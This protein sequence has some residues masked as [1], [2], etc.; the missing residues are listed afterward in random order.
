MLSEV[1]G[2]MPGA[3]ADSLLFSIAEQL[4]LPLLQIARQAELGVSVGRL[5]TAELLQM[6]QG[7]EIALKLVDSYLLGLQLC[8]EQ[9]SLVLEPVSLS[10]T[11][12]DIAHQLDGFAQGYNVEIE[13]HV[14]GKYPPVMAHAAGL[15]AAF[16]SLGTVLIEALSGQAAAIRHKPFVRLAVHRTPKGLVTGLYSEHCPLTGEDLKRAQALCGKARQP[17]TELTAT[18]GAGVFVAD[19]ILQAMASRLRVGHYQKLTGLAAT[20]QSSRQ[21][22]LV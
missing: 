19:S 2:D 21:L 20:L 5:E 8:Q 3:S 16:L 12:V 15:K 7:A 10:S 6:Q 9:A 13:L 17:L 22:Q 11:L 14:A 4:K 18:T 1:S